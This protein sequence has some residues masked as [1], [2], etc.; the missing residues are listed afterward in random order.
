[1]ADAIDTLAQLPA[2]ELA[3]WRQGA[4]ARAEAFLAGNAAAAEMTA[5]FQELAACDA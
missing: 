1:L 5:L 4:R 2:A 3:H